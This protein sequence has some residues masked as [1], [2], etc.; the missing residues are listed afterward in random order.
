MYDESKLKKYLKFFKKYDT[1]TLTPYYV[2]IVDLVLIQHH[3]KGNSVFTDL[4]NAF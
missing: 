4:V 1:I 2:R 3:K